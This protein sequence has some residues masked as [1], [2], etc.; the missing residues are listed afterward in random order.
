MSRVRTILRRGLY[1]ST[2]IG[3]VL[4]MDAKPGAPVKAS[5]AATPELPDTAIVLFVGCFILLALWTHH[6]HNAITT[7]KE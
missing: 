4:F 3:G 2:F 7:R 6:R 1:V 5:L